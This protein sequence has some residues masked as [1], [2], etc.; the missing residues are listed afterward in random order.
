MILPFMKMM[1]VT[2]F[3]PNQSINHSFMFFRVTVNVTLFLS[4]IP[5]LLLTYLAAPSS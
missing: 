1:I 5:I 4:Q 3:Q 2:S